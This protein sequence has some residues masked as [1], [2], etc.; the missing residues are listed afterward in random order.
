MKVMKRS[1]SIL[2]HTH[3]GLL[4]CGGPTRGGKGSYYIMHQY[5]KPPLLRYNRIVLMITGYS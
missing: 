4:A 5:V 2:G 1:G 3:T